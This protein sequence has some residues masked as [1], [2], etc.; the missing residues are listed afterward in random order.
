MNQLLDRTNPAEF[1][2]SEVE[3]ALRH[4]QV[5]ASTEAS[6]Y[7]VNLLA[8]HLGNPAISAGAEMGDEQAPLAVRL[9]GAL[10]MPGPAER[11]LALRSL[12]DFALFTSGLFSDRLLAGLNDLAYYIDIGATAYAHVGEMQI[13]KMYA[14]IFREL[15]DGFGSFVDV[16][17]EVSEHTQLANNRNLLSMYE[18]WL[19]TGSRHQ[20]ARL[21][22]MGLAPVRGR[23]N[24]N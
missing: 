18:T 15:A 6:F 19:Q 17:S 9:L 13:G 10:E 7:L 24:T 22:R 12:G 20:E 1:F 3:T 4:Q 8:S 11:I 14:Q 16:L 23:E 21:L 5:E 2:K